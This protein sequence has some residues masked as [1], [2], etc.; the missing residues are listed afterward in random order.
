MQDVDRYRAKS[1]QHLVARL[2]DEDHEKLARATE[3]LLDVIARH[4]GGDLRAIT[5]FNSAIQ[6]IRVGERYLGV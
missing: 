4:R 1:D 3:L 2:V 6:A 5:I